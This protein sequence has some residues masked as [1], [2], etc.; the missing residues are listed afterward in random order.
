MDRDHS[1]S[2]T[3]Q[4]ELLGVSRSS[5]YYEP[6][7][8]SQ[9]DEELMKK[10]DRIYMKYPFK[11]SRRVA[12]ALWDIYE[13]R[14]GR[15]RVGKLMG[16]MGISGLSPGAKTTKRGKGEQDISVFASREEDRG[17]KSGMGL[18]HHVYTDEEGICVSCG[19]YGLV[20]AEGVES[21]FV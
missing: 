14:V 2:I 18:R 15:K 20:F 6:R 10:I 11:G 9:E 8:L 13:E 4:C 5:V 19:G 12:L 1:L 3:R 7:G 21:Q 17:S 16:E